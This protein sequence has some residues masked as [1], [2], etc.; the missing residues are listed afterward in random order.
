MKTFVPPLKE[1]KKDKDIVTVEM[2]KHA[3]IL[4]LTTATLLFTLTGNPASGQ[5]KQ[6]LAQTLLSSYANIQ[7]VSCEIRKTTSGED[8]VRMLSRV[9]Y[10]KGNY[11]HVDNFAPVR[12]TI[13]ADGEKLYYH[14]QELPR[15]FSRPLTAL[16]EEWLLSVKTVPGTPMEHLLRLENLAETPLPATPEHPVRAGYQA[17]KVFVVLSCDKEK[18]LAQIEFFATETMKTKTAQ[19]NYSEFQEAGENCWIPCLHKGIMFLP[20]DQEIFETRRI[21]NLVVNGSIADNLFDWRLFFEDIQ[22]TDD[23]E[24]SL[25]K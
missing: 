16:T 9:Y 17:E 24:A 23:F 12:R 22:F 25:I 10:K 18:H 7:T 4:K 13:I 5:D 8:T 1:L 19:Y 3:L 14:Q 20:D 11:L 2:S 6:T 21:D 15:G